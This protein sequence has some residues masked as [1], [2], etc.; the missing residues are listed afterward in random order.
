MCPASH[1][2]ATER[3]ATW[4]SLRIQWPL[5][6]VLGVQFSLL[7]L[8]FP[9]SALWT[10]EPLFHIDAAYHWYNIKLAADLAVTGN[11]IGYDPFFNAGD[12]SGIFNYLSGRVPALLAALLSP[13]IDEIRLY[14]LYVF[15][16][17]LVA[18]PAIVA[19][20]SLLRLSRLEAFIAGLLGILMWWVSYLHW[21]YT[22]GLVAYVASCY[23]GVLLAALIVRYLEGGGG[24]SA[25]IWL[26][27]IGA[28][29]FFWHPLFPVLVAVVITVYLALNYRHVDWQ[30]SLPALAI[31]ATLSLLPNLIWLYPTHLHYT[32]HTFDARIQAI[33]N[34]GAIWWELLGT[35]SENAHGSKVYPLLLAAS[36]WACV[37]PSKPGDRRIWVACLTAAIAL[38][39]YAYM[40][41]AIP[42][43]GKLEPNRFAPAGYL[44]LCLPAARGLTAM[45]R[46]SLERSHG[47]LR[48][49]ASANVALALLT[50]TALIWE[51][52]REVTPGPQGRYGAAPPQVKPLGALSVWVIEWL[53]RSTSGDARVL[54]ETSLGRPHDHAH[55]AG[56]YAYQTQREFI[57][58]PYPFM[59]FASFGDGWVFGKRMSETSPERM[60]EFLSLY[61]IGAIVVHSDI[62]KRY[63]D[64]MPGVRLAAEHTKLRAYVVD[65]DC[66]Y[67]LRGTG[68]VE[69]RAHNRV[70]ITDVVGSEIVLKYHYVPG[71]TTD[72]STVIDGVR[73]LDDPKPFVR[74]V[75]PPPRLRLFIP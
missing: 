73:V 75:D 64:R 57:G 54:F 3:Q 23:V 61:N 32:G 56:Y 29:G 16:A 55:M 46:A 62:A 30:R 11:L 17:A 1:L 53:K 21:Y 28:F 7:A 26:G 12:I 41:A 38:Q 13:S 68:R 22:A 58:G 36:L 40:G 37:C 45:T 67:F 49:F 33:V 65:S 74:I 2:S 15:A 9:L 44:L 6:L 25:I 43:V 72:P 51:L 60:A 63:F 34:P 19:A 18:P 35:V 14:K 50:T 48:I 8:T 20:A 4:Q 27:L 66:S 31:I 47:A 24:K 70:V 10:N 39:A 42:S 5:I 71:L 59:H 52:W 69:E